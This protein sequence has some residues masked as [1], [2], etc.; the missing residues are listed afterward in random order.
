MIAKYEQVYWKE[1]GVTIE[2]LHPKVVKCNC[3]HGQ[4]KGNL[5]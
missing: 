5:Q 2:N 4:N 3:F 1:Y